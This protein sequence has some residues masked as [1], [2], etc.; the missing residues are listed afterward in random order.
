MNKFCNLDVFS[1]LPLLQQLLQC[2]STV[3]CVTLLV[4][5]DQ[6]CRG[7]PAGLMVSDTFINYPPTD[8]KADYKDLGF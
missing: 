1:T 8:Y 3:F 4:N 7:V 5:A 6:W 2:S